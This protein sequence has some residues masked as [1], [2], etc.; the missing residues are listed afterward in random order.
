M[1][2]EAAVSK[3]YEGA[4]DTAPVPI[5]TMGYE[6]ADLLTWKLIGVEVTV[7]ARAAA[8]R[9]DGIVPARGSCMT[10]APATEEER[11]LE[12]ARRTW[13]SASQ[14]GRDAAS[15]A[16]YSSGSVINRQSAGST[17]M[18]KESPLDMVQGHLLPH[19]IRTAFRR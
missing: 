13:V 1:L 19:V 11:V 2:A 17:S 4:V 14:A 9:H 18:V 8:T 15:Q 5:R 16:A 10:D 12:T 7:V 6:V 3:D